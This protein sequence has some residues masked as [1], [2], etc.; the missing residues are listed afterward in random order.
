MGI[1]EEI[2]YSATWRELTRGEC[3]YLE[4]RKQRCKCSTLCGPRHSYVTEISFARVHPVSRWVFLVSSGSQQPLSPDSSD[5]NSLLFRAHMPILPAASHP[6]ST[7]IADC[8][9]ALIL[10]RSV[11]CSLSQ[12]NAPGIVTVSAQA[13]DFFKLRSLLNVKSVI[14]RAFGLMYV[15]WILLR[16]V[17]NS[18]G[19]SKFWESLSREIRVKI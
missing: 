15:L 8:H 1:E 12:A 5:H 2:A 7:I 4:V 6:S 3:R 10:E 16:S 13:P 9:W 18:C 14:R 11:M 17:S 19:F